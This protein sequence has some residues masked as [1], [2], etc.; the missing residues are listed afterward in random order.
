[1]QNIAKPFATSHLQYLGMKNI[2][3]PSGLFAIFTYAKLYKTAGHL[4]F[5]NLRISASNLIATIK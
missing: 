1:M 3:N 2:A 4:S 5:A